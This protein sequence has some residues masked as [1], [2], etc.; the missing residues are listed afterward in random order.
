MIT[1]TTDHKKTDLL[2]LSFQSLTVFFYI[3]SSDGQP[4]RY[5]TIRD[6]PVIS[7]GC[8][9]P[10]ISISVGTMSARHPPSRS[11]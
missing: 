6:L 7:A 8:S 11:L 3:Q 10:I 1:A 2:W 9:I 5:F 4:D